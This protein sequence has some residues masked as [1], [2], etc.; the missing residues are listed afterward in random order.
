MRPSACVREMPCASKLN[1]SFLVDSAED[2]EAE[3]LMHRGND[4]PAAQDDVL[5]RVLDDGF[6]RQDGNPPVARHLNADFVDGLPHAACG[7]QRIEQAFA[8]WGQRHSLAGRPLRP[9]R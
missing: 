2:G 8:P 6:Q 9:R 5:L 1:S 7:R 4:I 3:G